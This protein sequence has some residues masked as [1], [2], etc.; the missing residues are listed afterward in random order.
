M[1][2]LVAGAVS[3]Y[4]VGIAGIRGAV[5]RLAG[6]VGLSLGVAI[7]VVAAYF[8]LRAHRR[9]LADQEVS[10]RRSMIVLLAAELGNKDDQTLETIA[11]RGGPA[12][13]AANLI[14]KGRRERRDAPRRS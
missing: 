9:A 2:L 12:G 5:P 13:D 7:T 6:L 11:G 14:L 1:W 10:S 3:A 4:A 8:G